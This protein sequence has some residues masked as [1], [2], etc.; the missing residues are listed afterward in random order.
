MKIDADGDADADDVRVV[1]TVET[2]SGRFR[3][4]SLGAND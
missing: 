1:P 2:T 3:V 4:E